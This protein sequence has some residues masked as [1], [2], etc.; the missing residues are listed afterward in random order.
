MS[1]DDKEL[2]AEIFRVVDFAAEQSPNTIDTL[3]VATKLG[4]RFEHRSVAEIHEKIK[5]VF[6]G[7]DLF[8]S[9]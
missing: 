7:R 8:W 5:D 1:E 9:E 4:G 6:R 3:A 2:M